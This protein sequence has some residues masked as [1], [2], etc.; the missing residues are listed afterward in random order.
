MIS[1][2]ELKKMAQLA[3][4]AI[5][6][7]QLVAFQPQIDAILDHMSDLND[8]DTSPDRLTPIHPS[9]CHMRED[10]PRQSNLSPQLNAPQWEGGFVVPQLS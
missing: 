7:E 10:I 1:I 9:P 6:N 8:V 5:T 3:N 2:D 4:L